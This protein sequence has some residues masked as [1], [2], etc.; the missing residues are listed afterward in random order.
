MD[1]TP[2]STGRVLMAFALTVFAGVLPIVVI[3][4]RGTTSVS[5]AWSV[6]GGYSELV[7]GLG[8]LAVVV[9]LLG[10]AWLAGAFGRRPV[11]RPSRA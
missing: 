8:A 9:A 2:I 1:Y 6:V 7:L 11:R 10:L 4:L 3:V 5:N